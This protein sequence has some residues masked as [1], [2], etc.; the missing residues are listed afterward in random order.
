MGKVVKTEYICDRC[1]TNILGTPFHIGRFR[2]LH[3]F[4]WWV[5]EPVNQYP[6][7]YI[8]KD[9]FDSFKEWYCTT[10]GGKAVKLK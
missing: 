5:P 2:Y 3:V 6:L 10:D 8:C 4:K 1:G 9:C 7:R